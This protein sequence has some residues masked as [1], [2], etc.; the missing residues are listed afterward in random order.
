MCRTSSLNVHISTD[1]SEQFKPTTDSQ[2]VPTT[3]FIPAAQTPQPPQPTIKPIPPTPHPVHPPP[4]RLLESGVVLRLEDFALYRVSSAIDERRSTPRK[5]ISSDKKQL[6]LPR[7]MSAVH[8][9][10]TDYYFPDGKDLPGEFGY[11][12]LCFEDGPP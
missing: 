11:A 3:T 4:S 10:F 12:I 7:T 9:D 1:P 6:L 5:F 2:P 8:F